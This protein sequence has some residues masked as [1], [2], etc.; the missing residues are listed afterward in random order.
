VTSDL[1]GRA[2]DRLAREG[3]RASTW[4]NGPGDRYGEHDHGYDKVLV[5]VAGSIV[6]TLPG[7]GRSVEL[8]EGDRLELPART[9]HGA[10]V[11]PRGV[12]C[13]EAHLPA[14]S[15]REGLRHVPGWTEG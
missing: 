10:H 9:T 8:R 13:L 4:G 11:G 2:R 7:L 5:A 15:L 6:F 1:A 14:G 3:L 12:T